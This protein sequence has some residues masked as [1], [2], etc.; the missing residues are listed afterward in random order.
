MPLNRR[1]FLKLTSSYLLGSS[2]ASRLLSTPAQAETIKMPFE[3]G[4]R[5]IIAYPQKRPLIRLTSRPPQLETPFSVF[6]ESVLTP[7]D[8]FFVRY[9]L[10]GVPTQ[11]DPLKHRITI[12]GLVKTPL[13]LSVQALQDLS[14][15]TEIIAVNQCSGNSRGFSS[16]RVP[17]GQLGNGAMGNARWTGI[18]LRDI[19]N[20]AGVLKGAKQVTF[21][22][23]DTAPLEATPA[24]IKA[25]DIDHT[26][27]GEVMIAFAMNGENIPL[28]NGFPVK[29][30][31]PGYYGTYWIK[32]LS[33]IEVLDH[34][35]DGFW[36]KTAYRIPDNPT[37][38]ILPGQTPAK[39]I[40]IARMNVRSFITS[41]S[42]GSTINAN[43]ETLLRGIAFD[44]GEGIKTV[45]VSSNSGQSWKEATLGK[46]LGK[47]SFREWTLP[48]TPNQKGS[49]TLVVRAITRAGN[50]QP[51][52]PLWNPS[53]YMRNV[54][55]KLHVQAV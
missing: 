32:H 50:T 30:I 20:K 29:L 15:P 44:G 4:E 38:S 3:N 27:D 10:S 45:L 22:G 55:E 19:L 17:G 46:D 13:S 23:L 21:R 28:L 12:R 34:T 48:F 16:P 41:L 52:V 33:D 47:Y 8:A 42:E 49:Y 24:F 11:I 37:H 9:H 26:L 51:E 25:L 35:F 7:N 18:P 5:E 54:I 36:M 14:T 43:R 1:N 2:V 31:V 6:N 39:T 40:P 53:G